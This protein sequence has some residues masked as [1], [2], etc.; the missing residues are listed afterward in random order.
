MNGNLKSVMWF[1]RDLRT[2]DLPALAAAAEA[3]TVIPCFVFDDRLL[4]GRFESAARTGFLLG[5]L[6]CLRDDLRSL[7]SDLLVRRGRPE[8]EI[9][10]LASE[11]AAGRV[12]W[13]EDLTPFA[14]RRDRQV[15]ERL[16]GS[17]VEAV[18]HPGSYVADSPERIFTKQGRPYTVF[19]PYHRAWLEAPRRAPAMR[20]DALEMP[21][22]I[23]AG[24]LPDLDDLGFGP[25]ER[26]QGCPFGPGESEA[27]AAARE[28]LNRGLEDYDE[29]RDR[30]S[31]GSSR[32]SPWIRWGCLSPW[33]W[34]PNWGGGRAKDRVAS[35]P[36]WLGGTST[37]R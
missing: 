12:H 15:A 25:D 26:E 2:H 27:R 28:F 31:G 10:K 7:G 36:N 4:H 22:E 13:T 11:C 19:S 24:E 9:P 3:G 20:P 34:R 35:G 32:L 37:P 6:S 23:D 30:P 16:A 21:G 29:L 17:D 14:R 1:R 5:C 8:E 18:E 33:N